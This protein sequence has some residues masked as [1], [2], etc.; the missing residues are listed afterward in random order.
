ME[1][2]DFRRIRFSLALGLWL[3]RCDWPM[4]R[5]K[6]MSNR[7]RSGNWRKPRKID[8]TARYQE[9]TIAEGISGKGN[10]R[11]GM[12]PDH[13]RA[14]RAVRRSHRRPAVDSSGPRAG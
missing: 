2:P 6:F 4:V 7:L 12:V 11:H 5:T 8:A 14:D 10:W 1:Q 3:G 9:S 13:A